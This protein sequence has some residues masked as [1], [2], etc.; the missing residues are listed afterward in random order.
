M[1]LGGDSGNTAF[2][3]CERTAFGPGRS[4]PLRPGQPPPAPQEE[5]RSSRPAP[6]PPADT[7][8]LRRRMGAGLGFAAVCYSNV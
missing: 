3:R 6:P 2:R 7:K 1:G 8:P 5:E 4:R